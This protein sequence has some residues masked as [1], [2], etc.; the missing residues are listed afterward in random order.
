MKFMNKKITKHKGQKAWNKGISKIKE[1]NCLQ[2]LKS[3]LPNDHKDYVKFCSRKCF[4]L[5]RKGKNNNMWKGG[6]RDTF[7]CICKKRFKQFPSEKKMTC[8][9][10]CM[11][12]WQSKNRIG[13]KSSRWKGGITPLNIQIRNSIEYKLWRKSV[14]ERDNYICIW[15]GLHSGNGKAVVLHA[16][17]IKP[18]AYYP[19]LRFAIDNGRTLCKDCHKKTDTYGGFAKKKPEI[20]G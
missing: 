14:F 7:C 8:S 1:R 12:L 19:E 4:S 18:F 20:Y 13:E 15:C 5:S 9:T 17:H 11:G 3:F 16:D 6:Q 2:C 10:K